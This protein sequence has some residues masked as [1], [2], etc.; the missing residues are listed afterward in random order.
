[1]NRSIKFQIIT[2]TISSYGLLIRHEIKLRIKQNNGVT[3][4]KDTTN[5]NTSII[6]THQLFELFVRH[7]Q[8]VN[9]YNYY[10]F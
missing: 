2:K 7:T 9:S 4:F 6:L 8:T 10:Y 3:L 1:M 5:F